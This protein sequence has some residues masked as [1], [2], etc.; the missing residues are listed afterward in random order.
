MD[1]FRIADTYAI[2]NGECG[3][4]TFWLIAGVHGEE[5]A[6]I[7]AVAKSISDLIKP[8]PTVVI[9]IANPTGIAMHA[10]F[11]DRGVKDGYDF[12]IDITSL[13]RKMPPKLILD[14]HEDDELDG[15]VYIYH[16]GADT[17]L[18]HRFLAALKEHNIR[19]LDLGR[20]RF[21]DQKVEDGLVIYEGPDN[22]IDDYLSVMYNAD[23]IV[24]ETP[25]KWLMENRIGIHRLAIQIALSLYEGD[26]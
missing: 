25:S 9:P 7:A 3:K 2:T 6:P 26:R 22:S 15:G 5:P 4:P 23:S 24:V 10:R 11:G 8:Y 12:V 13:A 14:L 17:G 19:L 21:G 1:I 16:H 18:P 20:P